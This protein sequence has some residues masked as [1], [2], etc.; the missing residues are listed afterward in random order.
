MWA[1]EQAADSPNATAIFKQFL[2]MDSSRIDSVRFCSLLCYV[3]WTSSNKIRTKPAWSAA[4]L[5]SLRVKATS[6]T[7]DR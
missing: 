7:L 4:L 2:G 6:F 3:H 5:S 1:A